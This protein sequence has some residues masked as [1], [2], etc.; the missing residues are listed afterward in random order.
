MTTPA[1]DTPAF[2][3]A[4]ACAALMGFAIQRGATCTVAAVEEVMTRGRATRLASLLEASLWVAGGLAVA[5]ALGLMHAVPAAYALNGW[6]LAGAALLGL[7]AHVTGACVFGAIARFASGDAACAAVPLG[8]WLGCLAAPLAGAA[9]PQPL[10]APLPLPAL[11]LALAFVAFAAWRLARGRARPW[12]ERAWAPHGAT[13]V[14][15]VSFVVLL[16]V[17]GAWAYTDTLADLARGMR[18][19]VAARLALFAALLGGAVAGGVTA[20]RWHPRMPTPAAVARCAAGGA[21]MGAGSALIPGSNDGL[22]L[23][24]MPLLRPYAW[25]AFATMCAVIAAARGFTAASARRAAS[26]SAR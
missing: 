8:F 19:S 26:G 21:L 18:E 13:I 17:A 12:A 22:I 6:T 25:V 5:T 15:G 16:L 3:L 10:A 20:G 14:I 7:G 2:A 23:V 4:A 9:P 11:P 1:I 24:G